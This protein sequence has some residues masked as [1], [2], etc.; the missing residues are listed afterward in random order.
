[1]TPGQTADQA[2]RGSTIKQDLTPERLRGLLASA[3]FIPWWWAAGMTL[4]AVVSTIDTT[5]PESGHSRWHFAVG[6]ISLTAVALIWLPTAIRLLS[7][8]GGS[9]KAAGVEASAI[10]ILQSPDR[11]I[12][13]LANL[14]TR[15]EE[16]VQ[17]V[18]DADQRVQ[19]IGAE[20]DQIANRYLPSEET[21]PD[22]ALYDL[23]RE[24][25]RIRRD[26]PRGQSRTIAMNKLVNQVRIRAAASPMSARRKAPAL[27]RSGRD[28]DRIV[29][30]AL[31][32]GSPAAEFCDDLLR[33]FSSSV[34][35]F[36]QYHSLLALSEIAPILSA[37]DRTR[38]I[39]VL[40]RE[41]SD[42]RG[43]GLMQD[44]YIPSWIDNVLSRLGADAKID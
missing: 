33:I 35:A 21:L 30:L 6:A 25:E 9:V 31:A 26:N 20:F 18:P 23:A 37:E 41:K 16:L 4:V 42:P 15:T 38:A 12:E 34:S 22:E 28:G 17:E 19:G 14:R 11:L 39:S 10:G 29:G 44:P 8:V 3:T 32:E 36:E 43:V 24:Y 40:Q 7:L 5:F 2:A 13:D 1:M 27:L